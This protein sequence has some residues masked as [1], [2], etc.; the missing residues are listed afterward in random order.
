MLFVDTSALVKRY[1]AEDGRDDVLAQMEGDPDW[2]ISA[3]ARTEAEL[4]LC[5]AGFDEDSLAEL[6]SALAR[7]W[8]RMLVVPVDVTCLAQASRIGCEQRIRT[9]DAIHL[10]AADRLPRPVSYLT[11]DARQAAVATALG[12][13]VLPH[14]AS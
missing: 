9:L 4:T 1:L 6:L 5:H 13:D 14:Q 2:A 11:F 8:A 12:L 3:V 10:A 7:D